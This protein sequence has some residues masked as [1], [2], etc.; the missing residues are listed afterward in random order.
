M[1]HVSLLHDQRMVVR[2]FQKNANRI[3]H[4]DLYGHQE[5]DKAPLLFAT[6]DDLG[7]YWVLDRD[8]Q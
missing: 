3:V 8:D 4:Q 6:L 1:T 2:S 7:A 5:P